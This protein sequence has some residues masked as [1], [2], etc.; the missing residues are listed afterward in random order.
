VVD[1]KQTSSATRAPAGA[2]PVNGTNGHAPAN[3]AVPH[4]AAPAG[5]PP[6]APAAAP[7][8]A[9]QAAPPE[10]AKRPSWGRRLIFLVILL[11]ILAVGGVF[12]YRWYY[13]S[14]HFVTTDNAQISGRMV[15]VGPLAA[16]RIAEIRYDVGQRVAKDQVVA[17]VYAPVPV[18][19]TANGQ[20]RLEF[21]Q[22]EDAV[23]EVTAPVDG[24]V[25]ARNA[26][27]GDT[28]P[29]GQSLL[30]LV[31]PRLLWINANI[32]ETQVRKLRPGQ[33]VD[34]HID[35]LGADVGGH[36]VAITPASAATFSLVPQQNLSG[37]FTKQTQLV[38]VKIEL[39][40]PDNRLTIGTSVGVKIRV[41]D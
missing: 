9:T 20:P 37:N 8:A 39:D 12:A 36:V 11:A 6:A 30:T 19:T 16:G 24:V 31:D 33:H 10:A 2:P 3:G 40:Q 38:P 32:E 29:A 23:V 18:G 21:R 41:A 34:I 22:T 27:A 25:I 7:S 4:G 5:A 35:A 15:Q 14:T 17:R 28:V 26:N 13:D 1:P